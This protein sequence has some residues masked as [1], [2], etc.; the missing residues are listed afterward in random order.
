MDDQESEL[1]AAEEAEECTSELIAQ[2]ATHLKRALP[3]E[4]S[5]MSTQLAIHMWL[6]D[7]QITLTRLGLI[8]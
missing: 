4:V 3:I 1:E 7:S 5:Q 6:T 8:E 2:L